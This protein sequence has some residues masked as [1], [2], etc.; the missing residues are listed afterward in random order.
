LPLLNATEEKKKID[1]FITIVSSVGR[2]NGKDGKPPMEELE[3]YRKSMNLN[4]TK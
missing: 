1:I 3:K 4:M 2:T